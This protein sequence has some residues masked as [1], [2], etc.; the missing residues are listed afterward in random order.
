MVLLI[1]YHANRYLQRSGAEAWFIGP[2]QYAVHV[3]HMPLFFVISGYLLAGAVDRRGAASSARERLRR[4]GL[5][6]FAAMVT[7]I[8]LSNLAHSY[9]AVRKSGP[10]PEDRTLELSN[11]FIA[12]PQILWFLVY[13]LILTIAGIGIWAA[14]RGTR[15]SRW[16]GGAFRA[17]LGGPLAIPVLAL[18]AAA[19]LI[20][21]PSWEASKEVGGTFLPHPTLLAY[22]GLF[23]AFGWMLALNRDLVPRV[24]RRPALHLLGGVAL[25]VAGYWT[26]AHQSSLADE[27]GAHAFALLVG[28]GLACWLLLFGLWGVFARLIPSER[29]VLRYIADGS[30]WIY[31][32][33]LPILL[34]L[35]YTLAY[36]GLPVEARFLLAVCGALA[37]ALLTY[38]LFVRHTPLGDFVGGRAPRRKVRAPRQVQPE[39]AAASSASTGAR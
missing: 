12:R 30:F 9:G 15:F 19:A 18:L 31:L 5:P 21:S 29:P 2:L 7:V 8:P 38:A 34:M 33:H 37:G 17:L 20:G 39:P 13:L 3:F 10:M 24:E 25:V 36:T 32:I 22:Y 26:I 6:L 27:R 35:E 1:P 28:P 16:A 4:I 14:L 11:L 23:L